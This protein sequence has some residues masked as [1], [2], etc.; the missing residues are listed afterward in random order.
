MKYA[1]RGYPFT[2]GRTFYLKSDKCGSSLGSF[3]WDILEEAMLFERYEARA[4]QQRVIKSVSGGMRMSGFMT[5]F[6]CELV[7]EKEVVVMIVMNC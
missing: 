3:N 2:P 5:G 4:L 1:V 7:P 6:V